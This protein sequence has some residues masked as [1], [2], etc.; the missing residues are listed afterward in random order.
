MSIP[1]Y[2]T[3]C[4]LLGGGLAG[5]M[6]AREAV[7]AGVRVT[8]LH[9][10]QGASPW[11][12]GLCIPAHPADSAETFLRDTLA[13]GQG[14]SE[15]A[16]AAA[17]C[18]DAP[19]M[20]REIERLGLAF[21]RE[22]KGYQF[23]RPLGATHPRVMSVGNDT[24]AQAL[25]ALRA[26]VA[27]RVDER[28][29]TRAVRLWA[30]AGRVCGALAFD[31]R[32][33]TWCFIRATATVLAC[34]GFCGIYPFSTNK[35]DSGGDAAA[36]AY[37]AGAQLCDMEFIQFEPSGAI[38]PES[39]RGTSIITTMFYEGAVLRNA[40]G[41]RFMLRHGPDGE[42]VG[43]DAL[44]RRIA[45]EIAAGRGS[46]H[47]GV[48]FD[49]TALGRDTLLRLYPSY[50]ER[51]RRVGIDIATEW[52]EL[53][54]VA[55]TSL[56]GVSADARGVTDVDSLFVCGEAMGGLHGANRIG[57]NAGL[58]TLVFGR[59]AG[60]AAAAYIAEGA[61][62]QSRAD[63]DASPPDSLAALTQAE[64]KTSIRPET[65]ALRKTLQT[66]LSEAAGVLRQETALQKASEILRQALQ[67]AARLRPASAEEAFA[68]LRLENDL[69]AG[70]LVC[71]SALQRD[72]S[73]GCHIRTD[74]PGAPECA[75][76]VTVRRSEQGIP[77]VARQPVGLC[78]PG[79]GL[80]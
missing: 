14:V 25:T 17:L 13:S 65:D 48:Y 31:T 36:I 34:G 49:A 15:P 51:Y 30:R 58:E 37:A 54:P 53:A 41:E 20:Q 72:S 29:H 22:G 5:W 4:L 2:T 11:V 59:R 55:H 12:H 38:W 61:Q 35:R 39:L 76:H 71:L 46:P 66:A 40:Q 28:P 77:S 3:D 18:G 73:L 7:R 70:L 52:I 8:L 44:A 33:Q 75:Y 27:G 21:N 63:G 56:G 78:P 74:R 24:G 67:N 23:L 26:A 6:A 19:E 64:G 45:E 10:G 16:L 79:N 62:A 57:G 68:R 60:R 43:K 9:D 47:G 32:A 50:V 1:V 42:R 80:G 69:T